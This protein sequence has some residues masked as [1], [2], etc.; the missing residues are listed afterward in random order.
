MGADIPDTSQPRK[1]VLVAGAGLAGLSCAYELRQQG[2]DVLILEARNRIGGRVETI[3]AFLDNQLAEAGPYFISDRHKLTYHYVTKEVPTKELP[4]TILR[5]LPDKLPL[6]YY[7]NGE[8][9][10]VPEDGKISQPGLPLTSLEK[11]L[12]IYGMLGFYSTLRELGDPTA[13]EWPPPELKKY[14]DMSFLQYLRFRGASDGAIALLRPWFAPWLDQLDKVSALMILRTAA[15]GFA[16]ADQG[17]KWYTLMEGMKT[18]PQAFA[19]KLSALGVEIRT[20]SPIEEITQD[21]NSVTVTYRGG[22]K[23]ESGDYLVCTIPFPVLKNIKGIT[24]FSQGKQN[25]IAQLENSSIARFYLQFNV[26]VWDGQ[27]SNGATFTDL[28]IMNLM[29]H[30]YGR[31]GKRG[32][33]QSYVSGDQAKTIQT[34]KESERTD[35][36]LTQMERVYPGLAESFI[37]DT[38]NSALKAHATKFWDDD[39]WALGAYICFKPGQM[40]AL[41]PDIASPEGRIYFAGD[42]TSSNPGWM[43]GAFESGIRAASQIDARISLQGVLA[44]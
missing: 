38:S 36:L 2:H 3:D 13:P 34:M 40:I 29:E 44:R 11:Q 1:K 20:S 21:K 18:L 16:F 37:R 43:Q 31:P 25:A 23:P 14:D 5:V 6:R 7:L 12:G 41:M 30:S 8:R 35:F 28:P 39:P 26:R 4:L 17:Q 22:L 42:H 24:S 27:P 19:A 33:L 32:I 10:D 15:I 9:I